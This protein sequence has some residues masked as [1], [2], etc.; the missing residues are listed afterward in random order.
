[1]PFTDKSDFHLHKVHFGLLIVG[2]DILSVLVCR[3]LLATM[4]KVNREFLEVMD[5]HIIKQS[6]F[7]TSIRD[8]K[9]DKTT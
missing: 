7:T 9:L 3:Y 6:K 1:M 5:N 4:Q 2:I 8:I